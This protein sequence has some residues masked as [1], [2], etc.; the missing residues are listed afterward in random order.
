M[1]EGQ[2]LDGI[3]EDTFK[4][5]MHHYNMPPYSTG[6]A[7]MM[8]STSRREIGH[9]ALA[10]RALEKVLPARKNSPM[11]YARYRVIAQTL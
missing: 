11:P 9:G 2:N 1:R 5:Y 4:R 3:S 7:K 10:A 6:E 8:R